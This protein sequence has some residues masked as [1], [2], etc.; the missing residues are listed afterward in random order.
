M[1]AVLE[2]IPSSSFLNFLQAFYLKDYML[3]YYYYKQQNSPDEI[4]VD[5]SE[6]KVSLV[7]CPV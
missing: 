4:S 7:R 1:L 5:V 3:S 2:D 6:T